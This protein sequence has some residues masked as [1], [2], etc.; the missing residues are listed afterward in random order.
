MN[1]FQALSPTRSSDTY[2]LPLRIGYK[3]DQQPIYADNDNFNNTQQNTIITWILICIHVIYL[4]F[5]F[6]INTVELFPN[7]RI[8]CIILTVLENF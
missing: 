2:Q 1:T 4:M 6:G 5:L 3:V 7:L 8:P